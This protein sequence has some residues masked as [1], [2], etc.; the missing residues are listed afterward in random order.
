MQKGSLFI[1]VAVLSS[2]IITG[3]TPTKFIEKGTKQDEAKQE[4]NEN[5]KED[6][7]KE[8][9]I[10]DKKIEDAESGSEF[11]SIAND[12]EMTESQKKSLEKSESKSPT[13]AASQNNLDERVV[14]KKNVPVIKENFTNADE[15]SQF[16]SYALFMYYSV[17]WDGPTF[18]KTIKPYLH[19]EFLDM[20]PSIEEDRI[21][22]Y[23]SLQRLF[24]E[25]LENTIEDYEMTKLYD[26]DSEEEKVFFRKYTLSNKVEIFYRTTMKK[27]S[28]GS[29]Q[30]T[31]DEPTAGYHAGKAE[32]KPAF[33]EKEENE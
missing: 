26:G 8:D 33:L 16:F 17:N 7:N 21:K 23:K 2:F 9:N 18:Y 5:A 29:W 25:Q 15:A 27:I 22:M 6:S 10:N 31:N 3:C 20:L 28:N 13:E 19:K 1:S 32:F 4:I 30:L 14:V 12:Y 11:D 24:T